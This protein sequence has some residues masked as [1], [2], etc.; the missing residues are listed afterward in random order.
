[1]ELGENVIK[2]LYIS[3]KNTVKVEYLF[4]GK[5]LPMVSNGH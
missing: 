4:H 3:Q 5:A 1:M 2:M